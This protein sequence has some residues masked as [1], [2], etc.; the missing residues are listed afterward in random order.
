[1]E[2]V[3]SLETSM[4]FLPGSSHPTGQHSSEYIYGL[5]VVI[6]SVTLGRLSKERR[7]KPLLHQHRLPPTLGPDG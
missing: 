6:N 1:M 7:C 2:A 4:N 3:P 5:A